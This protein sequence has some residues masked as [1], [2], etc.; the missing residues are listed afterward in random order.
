[1]IKEN[2]NEFDIT[3]V[4]PIGHENAVSRKYLASKTGMSD[5]AVRRAIEISNEPIINLGYGYF[6]PDMTNAVDCSEVASY[7]AQERARIN[8]LEEK[9]DRK[10]SSIINNNGNITG[11]ENIIVFPGNY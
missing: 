7:I 9:L 4:M 3:N 10:F 6:I 2:T 8:A 11:G 1:M 5:R